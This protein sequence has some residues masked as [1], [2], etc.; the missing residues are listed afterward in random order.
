MEN[1]LLTSLCSVEKNKA[2]TT[3]E[4]LRSGIEHSRVKAQKRGI[5]KAGKASEIIESCH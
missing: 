5:I 2:T 1:E 4:A 3:A